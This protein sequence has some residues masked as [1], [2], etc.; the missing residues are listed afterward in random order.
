[1]VCNATG[2]TK[3]N[4]TGGVAG[5]DIAL[6]VGNRPSTFL[7]GSVKKIPGLCRAVLNTQKFKRLG[8]FKMRVDGSREG[9]ALVRAEV[10]FLYFAGFG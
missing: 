5:T 2:Q 7:V 3:H 10:Q 8:V 6:I 1:M 9:V 4:L